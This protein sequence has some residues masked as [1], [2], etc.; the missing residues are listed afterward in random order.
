MADCYRK[1]GIV[2]KEKESLVMS[3]CYDIPRP[4]VSCKLGDIN[5]NQKN[6]KKAIT[7]YRLALELVADDHHGFKQ[8]AYSTWYPHLQLCVCYWEI[9][10]VELAKKHNEMA[11]TYRPDDSKTKY[12][13]EIFKNYNKKRN[14]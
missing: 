6:F 2:E 5:K 1:L 11:K 13:E 10:E 3:I 8:E 4:E 7:W 12:N 14:G 9:G